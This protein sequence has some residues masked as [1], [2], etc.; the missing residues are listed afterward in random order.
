MCMSGNLNKY[1]PRFTKSM[2]MGMEECI[3]MGIH[4]NGR[5]YGNGDNCPHRWM[6]C[7]H[8]INSKKTLPNYSEENTSELLI[9]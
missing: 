2:H 9:S 6:L 5:T 7:C 4:G 3:H 1:I 8:L